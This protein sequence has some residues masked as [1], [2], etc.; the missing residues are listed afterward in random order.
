MW[1]VPFPGYGDSCAL[2]LLTGGWSHGEGCLQV[3]C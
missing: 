1:T 3:F 2:E